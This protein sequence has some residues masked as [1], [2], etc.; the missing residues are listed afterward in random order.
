[1]KKKLI[2]TLLFTLGFS[3]FGNTIPSFALGE[4]PTYTKSFNIINSY[5]STTND[6][7]NGLVRTSDEGFIVGA[8]VNRDIKISKYNKNKDIEWEKSLIGSST[9]KLGGICQLTTGEYIV[10][11]STYSKDGDF[12]GENKSQDGFILKLDAS[13]NVLWNKKLIGSVTDA[14]EVVKATSD[15]GFLILGSTY[16][17]D[18]EEVNN[19]TLNKKLNFL[20]KYDKDGN[21]LWTKS[22][23]NPSIVNDMDYNFE[24]GEITVVATDTTTETSYVNKYNSL[25]ELLWT[26]TNTPMNMKNV[27]F[28]PDGNIATMGVDYT[29]KSGAIIVYDTNG[30]IKSNKR[31]RPTGSVGNDGDIYDI[32]PSDTGYIA[33]GTG[34][35]N[36]ADTDGF[37]VELDKSFNQLNN[38]LW[39]G[40][41]HDYIKKI[42]SLNNEEMIF[43]GS[44][45]STDLGFVNQGLDDG[46]VV[47][48]K[49]TANAFKPMARKLQDGKIEIIDNTPE[50]YKK[51]IYY[52]MNY[53]GENNDG[54][55]KYTEPFLPK[56]DGSG[57]L[58]LELKSVNTYNIE[59]NIELF[60]TF[61]GATSIDPIEHPTDTET[62]IDPIE[63]PTDTETPIDNLDLDVLFEKADTLKLELSTNEIDFGLVNSLVDSEFTNQVVTK[64]S[65]S[66]PWDMTI[67]ALDDFKGEKNAEN[68]VTADNLEISVDNTEYKA[69]SKEE[70][71]VLE[72]QSDGENIES[73]L[74]FRLKANPGLKADKYT[75]PTKIKVSQK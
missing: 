26:K 62:P 35:N 48:F 9:D 1:M 50:M 71:T 59:S 16:S 18:L 56:Y 33:V 63:H 55:I 68:I 41:K 23:L 60:R 30:N 34:D 44:S 25:G 12:P 53:S 20:R 52:R 24:T 29:D 17:T 69:L 51:D 28:L 32:I 57:K 2:Y 49:R 10:V 66:L 74:K 58:N 67:Q 11:G 7:A 4:L 8:T 45:Y 46:I 75:I 6:N 37:I 70:V 72:N 40:N 61:K 64:V 39:R 36:T 5:G 15:G 43:V 14:V 65:S 3:T 73:N 47:N 22:D 13:G 27:K 31:Y 38:Y 19:P 42:I 54:W 21:I